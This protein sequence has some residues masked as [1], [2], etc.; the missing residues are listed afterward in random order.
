M[1]PSR[2]MRSIVSGN[3]LNI[4]LLVSW[5]TCYPLLQDKSIAPLPIDQFRVACHH[6]V[7]APK[8]QLAR[9]I[10][11]TLRQ[12]GYEAYLAGGCVRDKLLGVEPK[13]FD[14]A[15]SARAEEVQRFFPHTIPVGAQFGVVVVVHGEETCE[16]ATFRL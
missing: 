15:T 2:S 12:Y 3:L 13:D 6:V 14:V 4:Y 1:E 10:V 16:V 11:Q 7:V 5:E 8:E 9:A